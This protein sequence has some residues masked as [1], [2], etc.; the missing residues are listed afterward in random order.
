VVAAIRGDVLDIVILA[1][2]AFAAYRGLRQGAVLQ[3]FSYAGFWGGFL[4]GAAA[5]IWTTQLVSSTVAKAAVALG[6][7]FL[8][9]LL[10]SALGRLIGTPIWRLLR[11]LHLGGVDAFLGALVSAGATLL[12]VWLVAGVLVAVPILA[13]SRQI[14]DSA[15]IR[16]LNRTLP[17]PPSVLGHLERFASASH[18]PLVFNTVDPV[19]VG[20]VPKATAAEV[21]EAVRADGGSLVKV[22]GIGCGA[23]EEGSGFVVSPGVVVTNAHVI[24][25]VPHPYVIA[26]DGERFSVTVVYFNPRY[27][28]ALLR[29]PGLEEPPLSL[30]PTKV[31]R[32]TRAVV[33][34]Y[35]GGGSFRA[36]A[37]GVMEGFDAVGRDIYDRSITV[38]PVYEIDAVVIPGNSGGP[39]VLPNGEVIGVVFS[40]LISNP[41]IGY[42]LSSPG[43]LHQ[44]SLNEADQTPVSTE[45]CISQ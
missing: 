43:V 23:L 7:A 20:P 34:G 15:V 17:S 6:T 14:R 28:L 8:A 9:A 21:A 36:R 11:R 25:G 37:A 10:L 18:F 1:L 42:A 19:A 38:R 33:L 3:L 44:I 40:R 31:P 45:G 39:L 24:A 35:P 4:V 26:R 22:A 30:D 13:L 32:G 27:D 2:V 16:V 5:S 29:V 12:A 41:D